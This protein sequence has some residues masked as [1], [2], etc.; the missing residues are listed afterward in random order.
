VRVQALSALMGAEVSGVDLSAPLTPSQCEAI[1]QAFLTYQ[2]LVFREQRLDKPQQIAFTE[3][4]GTLE[5][6]A[7]INR[8]TNDFPLL[9]VVTNRDNE[10]RA[11]PVKSTMWHTDKSFRA[12]PSKATLLHAVTLPPNGGDTCFANMCAAY[13]G[14]T[15]ARKAEIDALRVVHSWQHSRENEG[16][17]LNQADID[18]APPMSHPLVRIHPDSGRPALFLGMHAA[19]I[20]GLD[21]AQGRA[22]IL[23]LESHATRPEYVFYHSWRPGDLLMWDNRCLLHRADPN[24]D[25][26]RHPRTLHR[27]CLRGTPT[28]GQRIAAEPQIA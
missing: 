10:G 21:F 5:R 20:D 15:Q 28:P 24:F 4:F 14:L 12:A 16:L 11:T 9:H 1:E 6:H 26:A 22:L 2:L 19:Y 7:S 27:T 17:S 8:G 13:A 18:G 23:E 25:S 3:Q